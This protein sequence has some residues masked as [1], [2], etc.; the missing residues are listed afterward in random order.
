MKNIIDGFLS[1]Q[2]PIENAVE[3]YNNGLEFSK[4]NDRL[5][6]TKIQEYQGR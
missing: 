5:Q 4:I 2:E 6:T 3:Y 1:W